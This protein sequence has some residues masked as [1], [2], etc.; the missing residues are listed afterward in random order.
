M[1]Q[2]Q[3]QR[4]A[5]R[6]RRRRGFTLTEVVVAL[7]V[8]GLLTLIFAGSLMVSNAATGINGQYAQA[9]SLCQHKMDQLRAVGYGRLNFTE[10]ND[11]E[12]V[13]A[14]PTTPPYS[15]VV[16]DSVADVLALKNKQGQVVTAPTTSIAIV[17]SATDA[18]IKVV[19]ITVT[20]RSASRR[21]SNSSARLVGYIANTE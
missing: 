16:Q 1:E 10:L 21:I 9:L 15:F 7:F 12:I 8:F 2:G 13:D 4:V 19:T 18:R 3:D 17:N 6:R 14:T 5:D 11:A 20:W